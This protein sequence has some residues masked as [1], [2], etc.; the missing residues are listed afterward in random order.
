MNL[1][2]GT[3]ILYLT[4][5]ETKHTACTNMFNYV[6]IGSSTPDTWHTALK[7]QL[8]LWP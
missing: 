1:L 8:K 3:G 7:T 5:K 4:Y 6:T 2:G